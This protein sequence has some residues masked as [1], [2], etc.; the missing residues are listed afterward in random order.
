M[1][2]RRE[3]FCRRDGGFVEKYQRVLD[4]TECYFS[5]SIRLNCAVI[6]VSCLVRDGDFCCV[7]VL[8]IKPRL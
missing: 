4:D 2:D 7:R 3:M 5:A 1:R 6:V 8:L